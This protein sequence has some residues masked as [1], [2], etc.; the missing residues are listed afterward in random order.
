MTY[1]YV[2][3]LILGGA[4]FG[5]PYGI[6]NRRGQVPES[7]IRAILARARNA[8]LSLIDTA[9]VYGTSEQ[10]LGR[11]L[12]DF[13]DFEII[14]KIPALAGDDVSGPDIERLQASVSRSLEKL[15]RNRFD[16]LLIHAGA[17]LFKPGSHRVVEFLQ[18][19]RSTGI[20][21]RIGVSVYEANEIDRVL[22]IFTPDIVQMPV[23]LLDQRLVQSGH[24][25]KLRAAGVEMHGRSA[26]LQGILLTDAMNLPDYFRQFSNVL[27]AYSDFLTKHKLSRLTAT[28][29][30]MMEQ[31][32]VDKMVV[33]VTSL[34]E[35]EDILDALS[36]PFV[37][38]RM[39]RLAC[40]DVDLTDPR[41]WPLSQPAQVASNP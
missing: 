41:R 4:Q 18:L 33:G 21:S 15:R 19:I 39:D 40:G 30:F 6:T 1:S 23:N 29:G 26:F 28:L 9:V 32:G 34:R 14:S 11:V 37:L 3:K 38:P 13:P 22:G 12:V 5:M 36:R 8:Q 10:V 35:F 31:S 17:D 20:A 16:A 25:A 24:V 7:E 27:D 2:G